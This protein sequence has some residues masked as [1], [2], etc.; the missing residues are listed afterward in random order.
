[1]KIR[2]DRCK[3]EFEGEEWIAEKLGEALCPD[4]YADSNED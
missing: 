1:M 4:C 3:L 2:C